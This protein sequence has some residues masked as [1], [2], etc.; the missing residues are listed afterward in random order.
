[1]ALSHYVNSESLQ[2]MIAFFTLLG[3]CIAALAIPLWYGIALYR[4]ASNANSLVHVY[5]AL[6]GLAFLIF[7]GQLSKLA[8]VT[9]ITSEHLFMYV[10]NLVV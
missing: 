1:N 7:I 5:H 6:S 2:T 3:Y 4:S 8:H 9:G 10:V